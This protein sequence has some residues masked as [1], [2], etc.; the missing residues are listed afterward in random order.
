MNPLLEAQSLSVSYGN[1][2][3]V[4]GVDLVIPDGGFTAIV[5]PNAC[6]K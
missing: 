4:R 5:G 1:G 2:D 3:I 6:G